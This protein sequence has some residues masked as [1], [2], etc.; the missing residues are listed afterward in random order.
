MKLARQIDEPLS[1]FGFHVGGIDDGKATGCEALCRDEM[2]D[3]ECVVGSGE[4]VFIVGH[5]STAIVG[6][7]HFGRQ[8]VFTGKSAF[9]GAGRTDQDDQ[10]QFRE[11]EFLFHVF[12]GR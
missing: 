7:D 1:I 5:Q 3:F 8:E 10:R 9:A 4:V 11:F 2:Q 12:H 6:R